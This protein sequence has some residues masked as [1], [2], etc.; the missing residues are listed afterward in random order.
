MAGLRC[1]CTKAQR[2][3]RV[4][5]KRH[6]HSAFNGYRWTASAYSAVRCWTCRHW[7]RTTAAYVDTLPVSDEFCA[8]PE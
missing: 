6:N 3:W 1:T 7:W 5:H 4:I 8:S 2:D